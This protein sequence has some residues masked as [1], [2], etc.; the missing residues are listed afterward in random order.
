MIDQLAE[1]RSSDPVLPF[2]RLIGVGRG[3]DCDRLAFPT[4]F[5]QLMSDDL[6]G[7]LLWHRPCRR[8]PSLGLDR[9][10]RGNALR[11]SSGIRGR[12]RDMGSPTT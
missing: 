7:V 4:G 10:T 1:D 2:N 9:G 12:S 8:S 3:A 11:N 6:G 5:A